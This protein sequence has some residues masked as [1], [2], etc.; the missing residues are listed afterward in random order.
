VRIALLVL[1][2]TCTCSCIETS[3]SRAITPQYALVQSDL[4]DLYLLQRVDDRSASQM[5]G[6]AGGYVKR[7]A[8]NDRY[9]LAWR[10]PISGADREGWMLVDL[11]TDRVE[12]PLSDA[13]L[14]ERRQ[15]LVASQLP[16]PADVHTAWESLR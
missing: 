2:A 14:V 11:R 9:I 10:T 8:W 3:T 1:A 16:E 6:V 4:G 5:G 13:Q 12:G 7:I 15:S